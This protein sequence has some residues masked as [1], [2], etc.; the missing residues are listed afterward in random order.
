M[1]SFTAQK[2]KFSIKNF[3]SKC[4]QIRD[5][6]F[7]FRAVF[8]LE[9]NKS[10]GYDEISF[11]VIKKCFSDICEPLKHVLTL[12]TVTGVFPDKFKIARVSPVYKVI[13]VT[14]LTTERFLSFLAFLKLL[15]E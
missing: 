7:I 14:L 3:F 5:K 10:P 11:N 13:V 4:D 12:S 6:N 2:M 9:L 1:L 8:S 15:K